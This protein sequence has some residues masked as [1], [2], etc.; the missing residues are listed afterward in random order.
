MQRDHCAHPFAA[1][2]GLAAMA[3]TVLSGCGGLDDD[4]IAASQDPPG[5]AV[6][7]NIAAYAGLWVGSCTALSLPPAAALSIREEL[8]FTIQS[9]NRLQVESITRFFPSNDC[10]PAPPP[11]AVAPFTRT[12]DLVFSGT[13]AVNGQVLERWQ[14]SFR[15]GV[16]NPLMLVDLGRLYGTGTPPSADASGQPTSIDP[17]VWL[18]RL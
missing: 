2:A 18:S 8:Q 14:G 12:D 10:T 6:P 15:D 13:Q 16:V 17:L 1:V 11:A 4:N 3:L 9:P 7:A 5:V